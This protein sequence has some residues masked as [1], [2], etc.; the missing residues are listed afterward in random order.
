LTTSRPDIVFA[1]GLCARFQFFPK[2]LI[3]LLC[4]EFSNTC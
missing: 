3:T 4:R 1:A 2:N